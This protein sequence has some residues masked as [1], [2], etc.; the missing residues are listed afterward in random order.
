MKDPVL[1]IQQAIADATPK[2]HSVD[3]RDGLVVLLDK[4]G[5][6]LGYMS[7]EAYEKL[8]VQGG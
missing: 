1:E 6:A 8:V 5:N 2:A 4:D 3:F 7:V